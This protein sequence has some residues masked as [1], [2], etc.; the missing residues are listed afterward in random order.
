[1]T[2]RFFR[3]DRARGRD[4]GGFGLGLS[5]TQAY[6][7]ALGGSLEYEPVL[8]RGSTFRLVLPKP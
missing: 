8:P 1:V 3:P 4:H 6:L 7:R 2:E 5:I